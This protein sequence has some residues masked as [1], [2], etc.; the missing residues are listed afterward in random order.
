VTSEA[1]APEPQN[2]DSVFGKGYNL[3]LGITGGLFAVIAIAIPMVIIASSLAEGTG[4]GPP[5]TAEPDLPGEALAASTGCVACHSADGSE[6]VGPS[7]QGVYGADRALDTGETVVADDAYL[8]ESIVDPRAKIV[9]GFQPVMPEGYGDQ[10]SE[11]DIADIVDYIE[12]L[13]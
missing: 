2:Q 10:L 7:W 11:Q 4:S 3:F 1:P 8:A 6:L 12:S 5:V 13:G 9:A